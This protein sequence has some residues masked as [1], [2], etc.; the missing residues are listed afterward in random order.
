VISTLVEHGWPINKPL[1]LNMSPLWSVKVTLRK[2]AW[3]KERCRL[4]V[5]DME[6]MQWL[7]SLGADVNARSI[8]D[9]S[10]LSKAIVDGEMKVVDFLLAQEKDID[11]DLLHCAAQRSNRVEGAIIATKLAERGARVD[12][13]HYDN[14]NEMLRNRWFSKRGTPLHTACSEENI[15]VAEVL[16]RH[17]AN[18]DALMLEQDQESGPTPVK[19][20]EGKNNAELRDM[21][22]AQSLQSKLRMSHEE[23]R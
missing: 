11:S 5:N 10:T 12:A 8:F 7:I 17:G 15:P 9:Q 1:G 23:R 20:A 4:A 14:S 18:P 22:I 13:H 2:M 6:F 3:A 16:L 19:I 21:L